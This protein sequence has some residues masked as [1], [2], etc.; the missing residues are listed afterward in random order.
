MRT[1]EEIIEERRRL[2]RGNRFLKDDV[3]RGADAVIEKAS[4]YVQDALS[5]HVTTFL[6]QDVPNRRTQPGG[7]LLDLAAAW[8]LTRPEFVKM[9]HKG[10]DQAPVPDLDHEWST[11]TRAELDAKVAALDK[12]LAE[13]DLAGKRNE[14]LSRK[15]EVDAELQALEQDA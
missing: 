10:I 4:V 9:I 1:R 7:E 8:A 14:I 15:A 3:H 13:L 11:L 12:G 6:T 5:R 2:L